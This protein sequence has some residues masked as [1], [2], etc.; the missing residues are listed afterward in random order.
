MKKLFRALHSSGTVFSATSAL[1]LSTASMAEGSTSASPL[2]GCAPLCVGGVCTPVQ[3]ADFWP[4]TSIAVT[5]QDVYFSG[6]AYPTLSN[7]FVGRVSKSG[8]PATRI[9]TNL[10]AIPAVRETG[11]DLYVLGSAHPL[12]GK[13]NR[14]NA[15][16]SFTAIPASAGKPRFFTGDATH[17][18]WID[19]ND[20]HFYAVPREGG[21]PTVVAQS[22][23]PTKPLQAL[24][25]EDNLYWVNRPASGKG[26][27]LW[28]A[29]KDG[30][31]APTQL[32]FIQAGK[33]H[34]FA[35]DADTIYFLDYYTGL[36]KISKSGGAVTNIAYA[37][38]PGSVLAVDDER[39]YWIKDEVL[40]ATCKDGSGDQVLT[41]ET[42]STDD[43]AVDDSG[44]YWAQFYKVW[45]LAK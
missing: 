24:T 25:D 19:T 42:Y 20:G 18:Y 8:G 12:P 35:M 21:S 34:Q 15:N 5:D 36:N 44:I 16:G 31:A 2:S 41:T 38:S 27:T 9:L 40:T 13:V 6:G 4:T 14:L 23:L 45:K 1:L 17:L 3:I 22:G 39:L 43:I 37:D 26:W 33:F 28:K 10:A 30:G 11:G 32:L 7:G 29:P